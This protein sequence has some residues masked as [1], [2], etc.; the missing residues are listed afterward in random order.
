M[1][2]ESGP[3]RERTGQQVV[4]DIRRATRRHPSA[5]QEIRIVLEGPRGEEFIAAITQHISDKNF[6]MVLYTG[7]VPIRFEVNLQLLFKTT[8]DLAHALAA[9]PELISDPMER[10]G[11]FGQEPLF[12]Y[13]GVFAFE[14]AFEKH[15]I[16]HAG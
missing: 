10:H 15:Q 14:M 12:E 9:D 5:E 4:K 1:G 11:I 8:F 6:Q 7:G 16:V 2:Q 13:D 3:V